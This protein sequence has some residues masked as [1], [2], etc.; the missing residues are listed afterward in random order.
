LQV[1]V[2]KEVEVVKEIKEASAPTFTPSPVIY[3]PAPVVHEPI[4]VVHEPIKQY[5]TKYRSVMVSLYFGL[6]PLIRIS[7]IRDTSG[8]M[9]LV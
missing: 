5:Q 4:K 6:I 3:T 2:I 1:P 7:L 8:C 9:P